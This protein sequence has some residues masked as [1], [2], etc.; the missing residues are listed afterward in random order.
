MWVQGVPQGW[1]FTLRGGCGAEARKLPQW[2]LPL[3]QG[4]V[5]GVYLKGLSLSFFSLVFLFPWCFSCCEIP[6]SFGVFSAYFPGFLRVRKVRKIL[7]VFEV[8]LGIFEK[9]KEKKDRVLPQADFSTGKWIAQCGSTGT[10]IAQCSGHSPP[11]QSQSRAEQGSVV[12]TP[13]CKCRRHKAGHLQVRV[14]VGRRSTCVLKEAPLNKG[15]LGFPQLAVAGIF[16]SKNEM[17]KLDMFH[18]VSNV[19]LVAETGCGRRA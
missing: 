13:I 17:R 1:P 5:K 16:F 15:P 2:F 12:A 4:A 19:S 3:A 14:A 7:G 11:P 6:W 9:T 10:W 8:F 18:V